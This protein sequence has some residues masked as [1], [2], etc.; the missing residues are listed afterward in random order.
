MPI[1]E[2]FGPEPRH[3]MHIYPARRDGPAPVLLYL[4]GGSWQT[5]RKEIYGFLG[6]AFAHR[7]FTVAVPDYRLFPQARFPDFVED[8]ALALK[9]V[10]DN[11]AAHGGNPERLHLMGHSAGA[12]IGALLS[13][14]PHYLEAA[15]IKSGAIKS[16]TGVAGPYS[17]NPLESATVKPVFSHLPDINVARPI[18]R[19]GQTAPPTLLLHSAGD[20]TVP[21]HN[22]L[23]LRN[24]L[25]ER[26]LPVR[27]I[28]YPRVGHKG[29]I[30][31]VA[32]PL[33][34]MAP[35]LKDTVKFIRDAEAGRVTD[36]PF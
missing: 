20:R 2:R 34:F 23:H 27:H 7:G 26:R 18:K 29:I 33:R 17:F 35:V 5:G 16:F 15:G 24:A 10:K 6:K 9:W 21:A 25:I 4:Y 30:A 11:I 1:S 19:L 13:Y 3:E 31:S 12:H 14:D 32:G 36:H 22:S 8:A 28:V